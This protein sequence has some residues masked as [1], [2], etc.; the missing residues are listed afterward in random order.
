V[1]NFPQDIP[2]D[3]LSS[4]GRDL[5]RMGAKIVAL[6]MGSAG[7][8]L[9]TA[10]EECLQYMG[11]AAPVDLAAWANKELWV[12]CFKVQVMGTTGSGD[13]TIAGLLSGLLRGLGPEEAATA[14]VAVGACNVEAADAISGIRSWE[15]TLERVKSGWA[16]HELRPNAPGW[17]YDT[18]HGSWAGPAAKV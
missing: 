7:L 2:A 1:G 17:K 13:A 10:S 6:K 11:R 14:A 3:F 18:K 5:L 9:R 4:I 8:Y 15:A 16:R 12:P